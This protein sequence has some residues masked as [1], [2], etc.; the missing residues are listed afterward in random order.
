MCVQ[1]LKKTCQYIYIYIYIYISILGTAHIN[2][3][4][5]QDLRN[6]MA[7]PPSFYGLY[8]TWFFHFLSLIFPSF[9]THFLNFPITL[10]YREYFTN[11]SLPDM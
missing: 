2:K 1:E 9:S 6:Y 3:D 4:V 8:I 11:D 10:V 7:L 5:A